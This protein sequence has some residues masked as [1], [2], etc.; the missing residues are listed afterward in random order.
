MNLLELQQRANELVK[1][2]NQYEAGLEGQSANEQSL[3]DQHIYADLYCL[4]PVMK[5]L[6]GKDLS[7]KLDRI[8]TNN[9]DLRLFSSTAPAWNTSFS[10]IPTNTDI[11][12]F[13]LFE[14]RFNDNSVDTS[15]LESLTKYYGQVSGFTTVDYILIPN[16]EVGHTY[17]YEVK[18]KTTDVTTMQ[19]VLIIAPIGVEVYIGSGYL[20]TWNGSADVNIQS[21]SANTWYYAKLAF[22]YN[23]TSNIT[24][25]VTIQNASRSTTNTQT[26]TKTHVTNATT[27]S[28]A[29]F[30]NQQSRYLR[31]T[32]DLSES[33]IK[34]DD[35]SKQYLY[36]SYAIQKSGLPE[37]NS[38]VELTTGLTNNLGIISGF[39]NTNY[40]KLPGTYNT[41]DTIRRVRFKITG[42]ITSDLQQII[43]GA[44]AGDLYANRQNNICTW[45]SSQITLYYGLAYDTWYTL[46][47][48]FLST[49]RAWYRLL[50]AD[51]N[52]LSYNEWNNTSDFA[53]NNDF[54]LGNELARLTR[55]LRGQIDLVNSSITSPTLG[56]IPLMTVL[57][58]P[59]YSFNSD[60][61]E[62][63]NN[64][65]MHNSANMLQLDVQ[66]NTLTDRDTRIR[67]GINYSYSSN[68]QDALVTECQVAK[69][70]KWNT[71]TN[72]DTK[73]NIQTIT[74]QVPGI[75]CYYLGNGYTGAY[76]AT[77]PY[78]DRLDTINAVNYST[79]PYYGAYYRKDDISQSQVGLYPGASACRIFM[80]G[81]NY[82]RGKL[83]SPQ[84]IWQP[85]RRVGESNTGYGF[86]WQGNALYHELVFKNRRSGTQERSLD[87]IPTL[88]NIS[89][90]DPQGLATRVALAQQKKYYRNRPWFTELDNLENANTAKLAD[91]IIDNAVNQPTYSDKY[92]L[93]PV[94]TTVGSPTLT[95][96]LVSNFG[97]GNYYEIENSDKLYAQGNSYYAKVTTKDLTTN[98][99]FI[100]WAYEGPALRT[101]PSRELTW[102]N[103]S[104]GNSETILTG[105]TD[106]TEYYFRVDTYTDSTAKIYQSNDDGVTWNLLANTNYVVAISD[107]YDF[108]IGTNEVDTTYY[109]RGTIDMSK[110][111]IL[112]KGCNELSPFVNLRT[113][114]EVDRSK[115][116]LSGDVKVSNSGL[117]YDLSESNYITTNEFDLDL[118]T[119]FVVTSPIVHNNFS[120]TS[121]EA[122]NFF[123]LYN[124]FNNISDA[125]S[126]GLSTGQALGST[127][128]NQV[129]T[130]INGNA[131]GT[132]S[133]FFDVAS[134]PKTVQMQVRYSNGIFNIFVRFDGGSWQ[135]ANTFEITNKTKQKFK[136]QIGPILATTASVYTDILPCNIVDSNDTTIFE[137]AYTTTPS[138]MTDTEFYTNYKL[139][140]NTYAKALNQP[141]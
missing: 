49:T 113:T 59:G 104:S 95:D 42:S 115:F 14:Y 48:G 72:T 140:Y 5:L 54:A 111:G 26:I 100:F 27:S 52:P 23:D 131:H 43:S 106:N 84:Q 65:D 35:T 47:Y 12:T 109:W 89:D 117:V 13:N 62:F 92:E 74:R 119:D 85:D 40:I 132:S 46:E 68:I 76:T 80:P 122:Y 101:T 3:L 110:S 83:E 56:T 69:L 58:V 135:Q 118:S 125:I 33:Y 137:F 133:K 28:I 123:R 24:Y 102:F 30:S 34:V 7:E 37:I 139:D 8:L 9:I 112:F 81:C 2:V 20:H 108:R 11:E 41:V 136:I 64:V 25:T 18:F 116:N 82:T 138:R 22:S 10:L 93:S 99:Q 60:K 51:N 114:Q 55:Y 61:H 126:V 50:D 1:K 29:N 91:F 32:V 67:Q 75:V 129:T 86:N 77:I 130:F 73:N 96:N 6:F 79:P 88:D 17:E 98:Y 107:Q 39:N 141:L 66:Q 70:F 21:I 38:S 57:S 134:T 44:G 124:V 87:F 71:T 15:S 127:E 31:G 90:N 97:N 53:F 103:K 19:E 63:M 36:Q 121:S 94:L 120:S 105:L 45:T 78:N 16:P 128:Y 4:R